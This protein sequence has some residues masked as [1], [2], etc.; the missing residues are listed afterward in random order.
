MTPPVRFLIGT[1][2]VGILVLVLCAL[3]LRRPVSTN[4]FD[5][6]ATSSSGQ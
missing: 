6:P 3:F 5:Q 1:I 2:V 4:P